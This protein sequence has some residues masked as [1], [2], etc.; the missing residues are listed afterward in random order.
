MEKMEQFRLIRDS[1]SLELKNLIRPYDI[2]TRQSIFAQCISV[3]DSCFYYSN[4]N[5]CSEDQKIFYNELISYGYSVFIE[6]FYDKRFAN[7]LYLAL[8]PLNEEKKEICIFIL[9]KCRT[10]GWL[11]FIISNIKCGNFKVLNI[12]NYTWIR[13][14]KRHHWNEHLENEYTRYYSEVIA[15]LQKGKYEKLKE[16]A[17]TIYAKMEGG[18][19]VWLNHYMGYSNDIEVEKYFYE[20]AFLDYAQSTEWE[21]FEDYDLFGDV[22]YGK[23]IDT[24]IE[25]LGFSI[26]HTYFANILLN[27]HSD[28]LIENLFYHVMETKKFLDFI[29]EN[30]N[31]DIDKAQK[32]LDCISINEK[33]CELSKSKKLKCAPFIKISKNQYLQSIAGLADSPYDFLLCNLRE[34]YSKDWDRNAMNRET[35]FKSQLYSLF[36]NGFSFI[37]HNV[38]IEIKKKVATDLD[39]VI[40]DKQSGEIAFFQLKWQDPT[41]DSIQS[42]SSKSK[43]YNISTKKW[44]EIVQK[45]VNESTVDTIASILGINKK[46]VRK[47][48]IFLFV[49]GRNHGNYSGARPV[50]KKAAWLQWYQLLAIIKAIG[51]S[52][53]SIS[54]L[55][56]IALK[57]TPYATTFVEPPVFYTIDKNKFIFG[58]NTKGLVSK[59]YKRFEL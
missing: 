50:D 16:R 23:Y 15:E 14:A 5:D 36:G 6:K 57:A 49:L 32:I 46:Y 12:L 4:Q 47:E 26:K 58:G 33:N 56:A 38:K 34:K 21:M 51:I 41:S 9:E 43:N 29:G 20:Y 22:E 19:F 45:W 28:L 3:Y 18:A 55:Y 27:K 13:F 11:N 2:Q 37:K 42:L 59:K 25:F 30:R 40:I 24:L 17:T 35:T 54:N 8:N 1:I 48:K 44:I 53:L 10:I 31:L 52:K 7:L 39:A